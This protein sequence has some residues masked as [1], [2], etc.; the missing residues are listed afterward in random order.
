MSTGYILSIIIPHYQSFD[1]LRTC[2]NSIPIT[3]FIQVIVID[4]KSPDWEK[5]Q[6]DLKRDYPY[7][8][9]HSVPQNG[10]AGAARNAGLQL[11]T[12][13]WLMFA[14]ADD[15]FIPNA[16]DIIKKSFNS[17][18]DIVYFKAESINLATGKSSDRHQHINGFVDAYDS[19]NE[20][21]EGNLRFRCYGPVCKMIRRAVVTSHRIQFDEVKYSNDVMFSAKV[22]YYANKIEVV[23]QPIY[24]IT[25]SSNS[26]TRKMTADAIMCRYKVSV[27][28]H[29]FLR[30]IG[31]KRCQGIILRYFILALKYA[32]SCLIP[33]LRIGLKNRVDFFAGLHKW[34]LIFNRDRKAFSHF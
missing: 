10:G 1:F 18:A 33:M 30:D 20:E 6:K 23:K 11:A 29:L 34:R 14:D 9:F 12:G 19:Q 28:F 7:V 21:A 25:T 4:D 8:I 24:C 3:D 32:P 15:Y 5:F 26:L 16:F 2:L 13:E 31:K 27:N 17:K 22:G